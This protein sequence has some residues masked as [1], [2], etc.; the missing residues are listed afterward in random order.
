MSV[1]WKIMPM[2]IY[3]SI[4]NITLLRSLINIAA[5]ANLPEHDVH[6]LEDAGVSDILLP[7]R[8][9]MLAFRHPF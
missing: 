3:L 4:N 5:M 9:L 6:S 1:M 7:R 8:I 2:T